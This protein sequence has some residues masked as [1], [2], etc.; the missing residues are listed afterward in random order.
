MFRH[1][2]IAFISYGTLADLSMK[3]A[4]FGGRNLMWPYLKT[5]PPM[6]IVYPSPPEGGTCTARSY[7]HGSP[8]EGETCTAHCYKHG[9]P[10][11]GGTNSTAGY[12]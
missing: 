6:M 2:P 3:M 5:C 8:P 7:K 4:L 10:A 1:D 11:D 12:W 9:A